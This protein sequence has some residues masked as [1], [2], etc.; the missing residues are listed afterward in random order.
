MLWQP[1]PGQLVV[2][3][4]K[5]Q[6]EDALAGLS[7]GTPPPSDLSGGFP[8]HEGGNYQMRTFISSSSS[9]RSIL[10]ISYQ[11]I[12]GLNGLS[13]SAGPQAGG[14][15]PRCWYPKNTM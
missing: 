7:L 11:S 2:G 5:S 1:V 15:D 4:V 8:R 9:I 10:P 6:S 14:P 13:R 12:Y 3:G